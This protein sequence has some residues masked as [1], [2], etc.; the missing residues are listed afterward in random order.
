[1]P[2]FS[3]P[4]GSLLEDGL[5]WLHGERLLV[6]QAAPQCFLADILRF[7]PDALSH[8]GQCR[9]LL[10]QVRE[11]P[12]Q[13]DTW[14]SCP[15]LRQAAQHSQGPRHAPPFRLACY[16]TCHGSREIQNFFR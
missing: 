2:S 13:L 7:R 15:T 9:L 1:M 8:G 12:S 11:Q 5:F 4:E 6:A 14:R 3:Q 10:Y 16:A